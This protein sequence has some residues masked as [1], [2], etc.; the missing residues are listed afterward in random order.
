LFDWAKENV[1]D[2]IKSNSHLIHPSLVDDQV[3]FSNEGMSLLHWVA[4]RGHLEIAKFLLSI[5]CPVNAQ[6]HEGNTPLHYAA[7][8]GHE[9]MVTLLVEHGADSTIKNRD[10]EV[11]LE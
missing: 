4:D 3:S 9:S 2:R 11:A 6:D 10:G 1:L 5:H 8:S 7:I